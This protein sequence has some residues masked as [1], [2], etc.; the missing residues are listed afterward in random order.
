MPCSRRRTH[1]GRWSGALTLHGSNGS[2]QT[3]SSYL[4][5]NQKI[6]SPSAAESGILTER[7]R[8]SHN[9][10]QLDLH[11]RR[12]GVANRHMRVPTGFSSTNDLP[13][14]SER[15][16]R[17]RLFRRQSSRSLPLDGGS[18][19]ERGGGLGCRAKPRHLRL[20]RQATSARTLPAAYYA[21]L[22]LPEDVDSNQSGWAILL[23]E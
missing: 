1:P 16:H 7:R 20:S 21:A 10:L 9:L 18:R 17:R 11:S 23:F 8:N 2:T 6:D 12:Y 22:G 14:Y 4:E 19:L 15:W 3:Q 5:S 13:N